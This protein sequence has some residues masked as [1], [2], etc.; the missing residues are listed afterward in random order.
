MS[1]KQEYP[2]INNIEIASLIR[3]NM[4]AIVEGIENKVISVNNGINKMGEE[5]FNYNK[6]D[7]QEKNLD[8]FSGLPGQK[9]TIVNDIFNTTEMSFL[10]FL[11]NF[12]YTWYSKFYR[13]ID[14]KF[15]KISE[16]EK[17][18]KPETR[19]KKK[20]SALFL[21]EYNN[22]ILF[23]F[24]SS[25]TPLILYF[26]FNT[27]E[28]PILAYYLYNMIN[29]DSILD[30]FSNYVLESVNKYPFTNIKESF[31]NEN[32]KNEL[33]EI[34]SHIFSL[35]QFFSKMTQLLDIISRHKD[36]VDKSKENNRLQKK[37]KLLEEN[38][39]SYKFLNLKL[40]ENSKSL[41]N[42][43]NKKVLDYNLMQKNQLKLENNYLISFKQIVK[44]KKRKSFLKKCNAIYFLILS[45]MILILFFV[46]YVIQPNK[47]EIFEKCKIFLLDT[48]YKV[49]L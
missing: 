20:D 11:K 33:F 2:L 36:V 47:E 45:L 14:G 12:K 43:F 18:D 21:D 42:D 27:I 22:P 16:I 46:D 34:S 25:S 15:Q 9:I 24:Q 48:F 44:D 35:N 19:N 30:N 32:Y 13:L 31:K 28:I 3:T 40:E 23:L 1:N 10:D 26:K 4:L 7:I 29:D 5:L 8:Y 6:S 49:E 38:K 39:D 37:I 17:N 41:L